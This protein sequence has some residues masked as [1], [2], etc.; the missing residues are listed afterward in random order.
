MTLFIAALAFMFG[1]LIVAAAAL[2]LA[3]AGTTAIEQRL[4]EVTGAPAGPQESDF[5]YQRAILAAFSLA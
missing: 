5:Q 3:P 4:G 2:A 1:L